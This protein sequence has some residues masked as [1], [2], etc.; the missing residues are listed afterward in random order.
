MNDDAREASIA[1]AAPLIA[2]TLGHVL[3]NA[4]RTL[5]AI[6]ADRL[7]HDLEVTAGG[8]ASLTG[9][10]N[11][12]FAIAQV[13]IGVALDRFGVRRTSLGLLAVIGLGAVL[14]AVA[15]GAS[16]FLLAQIVLGLGC[17]GMLMCPVTYAA[18]RL[19]SARFGLWSG[20]IQ[21]LGNCGMLL[22]AS[23]LALLVEAADWRAGYLACA[24]LALAAILLVATLVRHDP[25]PAPTASLGA[26]ARAV[27]R[28]AASPALRGVVVLAFASFAAAIGVRGLWGGPW[29]MEVK[30]L[31][32][33]EA[34]NV[35]LLATVAL[36]VGPALW[37]IADRRIGHRRTLLGIGHLG[38]A[39]FLV[40]IAL[41]GPGGPF[42]TL[43]TAWDA[44]TLLGFFFL[45]AVQPLAFAATRAA[46]PPEMAGKALSGVNL[47][48]FAGAA[49]IQA[50]SGPVVAGA[51]L[52][53][54]LL[55]LAATTAACTLG[56]LWLTRPSRG[57]V[58][59]PAR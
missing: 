32:R 59:P 19:S 13:P 6:A 51:G 23:P 48:F 56:Y 40:L 50:A 28:L 46:V 26:D 31:A 41:G 43:P 53:S 9:A 22:S 36:V 18:K 4:V 42:G 10:Y 47:S 30:G 2:L 20:L 1:F 57:P 25:Q 14:A 21:A 33:V 34:G 54:G 55:F 39:A 7:G 37:G 27:L 58:S 17:A 16:G 12:S 35:L 49:V 15:G 11:L 5:P 38:A 45:I 44:A 3:S 52:A 24:A 8:L 29:L